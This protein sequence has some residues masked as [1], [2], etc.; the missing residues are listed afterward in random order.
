VKVNKGKTVLVLGASGAIGG[1]MAQQMRAAGWQVR[2]LKRGLGAMRQAPD[3]IHWLEGDAM[4]RGDVMAAAQGCAVIVHAVNPPGYRR[5]GELVL[6]MLDNTLAAATAQGATI[7]L[8]GTVYNYGPDTFSNIGEESPQRPATPKGAIRVEMERRLQA[9]AEAGP[10]RVIVVRAGDFLGPRAGNSWFAQGMVKPGRP[11]RTVYLP[12][13][14]G[15]GHQF[16]YLPDVAATMLQLLAVQHR[17]PAFANFHMAG[18][19]DADGTQ[20]GQAVQRAVVAQGGREPVLK[21]LPWWQLQLAAPFVPSF[22]ELL[23]M[24]Y[25]WQ[26]EVR[27]GN[28]RLLEVLGRETHTPLDEAMQATLAGMGCFG[29]PARSMKAA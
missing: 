5:W 23:G 4:Q 6:P 1:E 12:A 3:G 19:W 7:V 16:A 22:R 21:P 26:Q 10:V 28:R 24:R 17:L 8:P 25:L 9:A 27:M 14:R 29:P 20:L 13:T 18:Y 15:V 11:V 2:A